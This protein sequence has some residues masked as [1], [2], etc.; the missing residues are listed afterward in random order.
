MLKIRPEQ[1]EELS[2]VAFKDFEDRMVVHIKKH[3]SEHYKALGE[4][5]TR[6]LIQYGIERAATYEI[7]SE[8]D[9]CKYIDLMV[10][11][12]PDYDQDHKLPW[13]AKNLNDENLNDPSVRINT[14][15][16]AGMESLRQ[17]SDF[18]VG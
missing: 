6:T 9:V 13:A 3:F 16:D 7:V 12:G 17:S 2:K 4:E 15:Y 11:F 1:N 14:T 8:R 18:N 10:A 5:N